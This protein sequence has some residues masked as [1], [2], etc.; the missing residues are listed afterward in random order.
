VFCTLSS[1]PGRYSVEHLLKW[2]CLPALLNCLRTEEWIFFHIPV[3]VEIL[4]SIT[5]TLYEELYTLLSSDATEWGIYGLLF[6]IHLYFRLCKECEPGTVT[7]VVPAY[8]AIKLRSK[9]YVLSCNEKA[10]SF[11]LC[12]KWRQ[13][14]ERSRPKLNLATNF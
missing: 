3:L 5:G 13:Y 6:G 11:E 9:Q 10:V 12:M 8:R 7:H 1:G 14:C 2:L 4:T